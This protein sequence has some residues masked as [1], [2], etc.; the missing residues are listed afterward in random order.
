MIYGRT[1][2]CKAV[3]IL[4]SEDGLHTFKIERLVPGS[5]GGNLRKSVS[6]A[7]GL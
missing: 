6:W 3:R 2:I 4:S 7:L 1:R 5:A